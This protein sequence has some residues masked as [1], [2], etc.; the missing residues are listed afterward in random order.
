MDYRT[1]QMYRDSLFDHDSMQ[2]IK[3]HLYLVTISRGSGASGRF[4]GRCAVICPRYL[5]AVSPTTST[6]CVPSTYQRS[7]QSATTISKR[8]GY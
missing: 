8:K 1:K 2:G 7:R 4:T 6:A 5:P 3:R